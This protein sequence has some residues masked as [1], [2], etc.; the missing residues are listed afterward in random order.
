MPEVW[1]ALLQ[2]TRMAGESVLW[3]RICRLPKTSWW[4]A[5]RAGHSACSQRRVCPLGY[6]ACRAV[7]N[8]AAP[9]AVSPEPRRVSPGFFE[10]VCRLPL[11]Q[12]GP[13]SSLTSPAR[14]LFSSGS[15]DS[16]QVAKEGVPRPATERERK[17]SKPTSLPA[18]ATEGGTFAAGALRRRSGRNPAL[19]VCKDFLDAVGMTPLIYLRRPS[20]EAKCDIFAKCEFNNPGGSV[21]DRPAKYILHQAEREGES[22]LG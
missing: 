18:A 7:H 19:R 3:G 11:T 5:N 17:E 2:T 10:P 1:S 4:S 15:A 21:K 8:D 12:K 9:H 22:R 20:Q 6:Y 16:T 14:R 13:E